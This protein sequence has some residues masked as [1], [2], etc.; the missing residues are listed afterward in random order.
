MAPM[1]ILGFAF[2][3]FCDSEAPLQFADLTY[4]FYPALC[5]LYGIPFRVDSAGGRFYLKYKAI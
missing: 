5:G 1:R 3:A 4:G 2:R